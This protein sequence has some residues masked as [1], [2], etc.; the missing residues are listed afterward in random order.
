MPEGMHKH[1]S[2]HGLLWTRK[3]YTDTEPTPWGSNMDRSRIG[4]ATVGASAL[5]NTCRT[6]LPASPDPDAAWQVEGRHSYAFVRTCSIIWCPLAGR[7]RVKH[8]VALQPGDCGQ[9]EGRQ[10]WL[11]CWLDGPVALLSAHTSSC[12]Q[13]W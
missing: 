5:Y 1:A 12:W 4:P 8:R 3:A 7:A 6:G 11:L 9:E 13:D 10:L 2:A